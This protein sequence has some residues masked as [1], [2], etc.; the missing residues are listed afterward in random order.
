MQIRQSR[1]I[2]KSRLSDCSN[3]LRQ[4][5]RQQAGTTIESRPA[6][7]SDIFRQGH[8]QQA[9][10]TIE[11]RPAYLSDIFRQ[12]HRQQACA[13]VESAVGYTAYFRTVLKPH[14]CQSR[15]ALESGS[16]DIIR[17]SRNV[18]ISQSDATIESIV[19]YKRDALRHI[20]ARQVSAI[21][22]G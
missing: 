4:G 13:A 11:S 8:R 1:A 6:Y 7:L 21:R 19:A 5:H 14:G 10:T 2:V 16:P 3:A 15:A 17:S 9:G 18:E 12:G 20:E 22:K